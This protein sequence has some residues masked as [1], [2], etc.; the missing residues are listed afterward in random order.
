MLKFF[1]A[2][3][4][5]L[6]ALCL[7]LALSIGVAFVLVWLFP[8]I[9]FEIG[10]LIGAVSLSTVIYFFISSMYALPRI[11]L[12]TV[13]DDYIV[14]KDYEEY[15]LDHIRPPRPTRSNRIKRR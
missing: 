4:V 15:D 2:I 3:I 1:L 8:A 14:D 9:S 5:L 11:Y 13:D 6:L 7:F 10:V 12:P